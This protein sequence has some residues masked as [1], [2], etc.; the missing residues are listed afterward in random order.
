LVAVAVAVAMGVSDYSEPD[1]RPP[2][3]LAYALGATIGALLLVRRRW[4]MGVLIASVITL[5]VY[6]FAGYPGISAAVP[7]A[8]ALYT[9]AAAGYL[10]WSLG[11]AGLY[12]AGLLLYAVL[13]FPGPPGPILNELVRDGALLAAVLLFGDAVRSHRALMAETADKLRRAEEDR[14]REAQELRAAW[15]RSGLWR[16]P[17]I[18][19]TSSASASLCHP[20]TAAGSP[21]CSRRGA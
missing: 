1:T 11:I 9:A 2:D 21:N 5:Q 13:W 19:S 16:V 20:S 8:V 12:L 7:L 14:Q 17:T 6:H 15:P 3:S 4:P 10:R 18:R